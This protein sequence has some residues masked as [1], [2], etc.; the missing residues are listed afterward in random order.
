PAD[1]RAV[2]R[3][4]VDR[5]RLRCAER[6]RAVG[7]RGAY[8]EV[9][10]LAVVPHQ[11][12]AAVLEA[13]V[14]VHYRDA[15]PVGMGHHTIVRLKDEAAGLHVPAILR[16]RRPGREAVAAGGAARCGIPGL[17]DF[18]PG[19]VPHALQLEAE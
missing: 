13:A 10:A 17:D 3:A 7:V 12:G 2:E 5:R 19:H 4:L 15:A 1:G 8:V 18:Y 6:L 14:E 11:E 9:R 16:Q